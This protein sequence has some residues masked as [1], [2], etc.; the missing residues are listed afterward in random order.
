MV[1]K[2]GIISFI[3]SSRSEREATLLGGGERAQEIIDNIPEVFVGP[4]PKDLV[5]FVVKKQQCC[6]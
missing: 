5:F 2:N 4:S 1:G 6:K 3:I